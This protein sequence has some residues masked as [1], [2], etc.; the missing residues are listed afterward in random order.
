MYPVNC[1]GQGDHIF[2]DIKGVIWKALNKAFGGGAGGK[3]RVYIFNNNKVGVSWGRIEGKDYG[4]GQHGQTPFKTDRYKKEADNHSINFGGA[5]KSYYAAFDPIKN[6]TNDENNGIDFESNI[7]FLSEWKA[8][9]GNILSNIIQ[10]L[11]IDE[12][13]F[14]R[15]LQ[16]ECEHI[17]NSHKSSGIIFANNYIENITRS[18]E[19]IDVEKLNAIKTVINNLTDLENDLNNLIDSLFL[20]GD[21]LPHSLQQDS[22]APIHNNLPSK[23][24]KTEKHG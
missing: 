15:Y 23:S 3:N 12:T 7:D 4:H 16:P 19:K 17:D 5:M 10:N 11:I 24:D 1:P 14:C 21:R 2:G 18:K 20:T 22:N 9:I 8:G 13:A 6:Y